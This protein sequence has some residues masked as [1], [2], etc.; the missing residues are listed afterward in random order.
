MRRDGASGASAGGQGVRLPAREAPASR[1]NSQRELAR[2][3]IDLVD[4]DAPPLSP[5]ERVAAD[6]Y[7]RRVW[8]MHPHP[9]DISADDDEWE[10]WFLRWSLPLPE[11]TDEHLHAFLARARSEALDGT[12]RPASASRMQRLRATVRGAFSNAM[13]RRLIEWDPWTAVDPER[14]RDQDR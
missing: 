1:R 7:L 4:E 8:V 13:K 10:Q 5:A 6:G 2:A 11:V 3:V 9:N 14:L 12:P